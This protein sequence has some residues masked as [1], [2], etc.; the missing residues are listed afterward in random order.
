M[1]IWIKNKYVFYDLPY[2]Q[3]IKITHLLDPMHIF[4]NV[5]SYL[6]RN[7][8]SE[9][10]DT[11]GIR[12]DI[13]SSNTKNRHWPRQENLGE[14]VPCWSFKEGDVPWVLKKNDISLENEVILVVKVSYLYGPSQRHCFTLDEHFGGL[15]SHNH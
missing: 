15:K 9:K 8:P 11:F 1:P 14:V 6:C 13:I 4:K 2:C 7:M 3:H 10:N 12:R 5:S